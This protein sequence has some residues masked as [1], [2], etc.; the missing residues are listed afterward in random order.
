MRIVAPLLAAL[1]LSSTA[2]AEPPTSESGAR[3]TGFGFASTGVVLTGFGAYFAYKGTQQGDL[4]SGNVGIALLAGG[5]ITSGIGVSMIFSGSATP[6]KP[7]K[8]KQAI[9]IGPG[10]ASYVRSF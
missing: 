7:D 2:Y 8:P 6:E 9:V 10:M 4:T 3:T 1:L 5:I